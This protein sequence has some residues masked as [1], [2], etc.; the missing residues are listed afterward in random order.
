VDEWILGFLG[1]SFFPI[2]PA[3][4]QSINPVLSAAVAELDEAF[5]F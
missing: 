3:I 5:V 1:D 4:H 2:Y